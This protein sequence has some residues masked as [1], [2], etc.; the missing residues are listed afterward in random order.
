MIATTSTPKPY[1]VSVMNSDRRQR[2]EALRK[3]YRLGN[4]DMARLMGSN[5]PATYSDWRHGKTRTLQRATEETLEAN[6]KR[7]EAHPEQVISELRRGEVGGGTAD[8]SGDLVDIISTRLR[9]LL[10]VLESDQVPLAA[11]VN[12]LRTMTKGLAEFERILREQLKER[13]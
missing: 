2:A 3:K 13:R 5:R 7:L 6:L 12:D 8:D 11:K 4:G 10:N 1:T 9:S